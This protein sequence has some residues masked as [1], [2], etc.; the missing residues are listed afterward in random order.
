MKFFK[1]LL[2]SGLF[3][4]SSPLV[5]AEGVQL[6]Y[7]GMDGNN[8]YYTVGCPN[9]KTS[10]VVVTFD[11]INTETKGDG[12]ATSKPEKAIKTCINTYSGIEACKPD[13]DIVAAAQESCK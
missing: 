3:L 7:A 4:T 9:D 10:S 2:I 11:H 8:R 5:H 12:S 6:L 13:W 1:I